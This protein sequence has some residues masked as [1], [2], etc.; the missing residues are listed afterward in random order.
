M[1]VLF[2]YGA[3]ATGKLT[4]AKEVAKRSN[5]RLFHNH[6]TIDLAKEIYPDFDSQSYE[7][8]SRLRLVT[9]EY[10]AEHDTDLIFTFVFEDSPIDI[11]FVKKV[12]ETVA[13]K[14]GHV[15][16]VELY[17]PIEVLVS[18]VANESRKVVGKL[19]DREELKRI[20]SEHNISSTVPFDDV[21]KI[22]TS[23]SSPVESAEL[24][25]EHFNLI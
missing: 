20:Y 2:I 4:I 11:E 5:H 7:L 21:L 10:A 9:I 25:I 24:V 3:P 13:N 23:R 8:A 22:D 15:Y 19:T 17:A 18:R 6:L 12:V 16:F 1:N 14:G